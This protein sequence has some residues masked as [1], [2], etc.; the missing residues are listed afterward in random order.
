M[1]HCAE[2]KW[3][4]PYHDDDLPAEDRVTVA[5]HLDGCEDCSRT[6]LGYQS[7]SG[8]FEKADAPAT[9]SEVEKRILRRR[10]YETI[11]DIEERIQ[12]R[13]AYSFLIAAAVALIG[14]FSFSW[15]AVQ[16]SNQIVSYWV[17]NVVFQ[18]E[19]ETLD[20]ELTTD[21]ETNFAEW[22]SS[23]LSEETPND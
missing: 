23:A 6:L 8:I 18:Q 10:I 17:E 7:I 4:G 12:N 19:P 2:T 11:R 1:N 15:I 20:P 3:I 21:T 5:E 13:F 9:A 22:M 16:N 14:A